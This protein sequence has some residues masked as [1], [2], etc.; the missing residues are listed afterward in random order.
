M[1]PYKR[2]IKTAETKLV[3]G[4]IDLLS[5][6]DSIDTSTDY[7]SGIFFV[8][9]F[10][11]SQQNLLKIKNK[12]SFINIDKGYLQPN[13][14]V[15]DYWRMSY[16]SFQQDK[17]LDVPSDRLAIFKDFDI[18]PWNKKGSYI[19]ILAPNLHPVNYYSNC[20][21]EEWVQ[22]VKVKLLSLT[23]R[24]VFVRYKD[25]KKIRSYDPLVKYL[26]D[27]YAVISLQSIGAVESI[28]N[29]V[30]VIN[31]A[32][33]CLD[34][35]YKSDLNNIENLEYPENRHEWFKS[36]S[37]SQFTWE[38]MQTGKALALIKQHYKV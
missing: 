22:D 2:F 14:K 23:D 26:D 37:Y 33:S 28:A 6:N 1:L 27:C 7:N 30:P 3:D 5:T 19:I 38:E 32:P 25:N 4:M 8:G 12:T 13:L 34:G 16:N 15:T 20:D 17:L 36:L 10:R 29:G 35:L 21:I 18:K 9:G 24:K 31:L 11:T